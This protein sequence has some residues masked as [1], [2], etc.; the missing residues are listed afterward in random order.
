MTVLQTA[1]AP[2][3]TE[4]RESSVGEAGSRGGGV[5]ETAERSGLVWVSEDEEKHGGA[6]KKQRGPTL[7]H[8][9]ASD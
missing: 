2:P 6:S 5:Y 7:N 3:F 4:I 9:A 8:M 1:K